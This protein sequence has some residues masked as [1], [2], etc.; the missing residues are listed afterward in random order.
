MK[1]KLEENNIFWEE[2]TKKNFCYDVSST[3]I[4]SSQRPFH[5][6]FFLVEERKG[7][8]EDAVGRIQIP[9]TNS[10]EFGIIF[11]LCRTCLLFVKENHE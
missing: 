11:Y 1:L 5:Y 10:D 8:K 7:S 3:L 9:E 6:V 2:E 4:E